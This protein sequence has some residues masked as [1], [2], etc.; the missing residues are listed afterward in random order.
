MD[1][2]ELQRS[3]MPG[4]YKKR[5]RTWNPLTPQLLVE[6]IKTWTLNN[7]PLINALAFKGD[8]P[9]W[10]MAALLNQT[11]LHHAPQPESL[12]QTETKQMLMSLSFIGSSVERHAQQQFV[13]QDF[14]PDIPDYARRAARITPGKGLSALWVHQTTPFIAY[15][16]QLADQIGHPYRD[17]VMSLVEYNGP[18]VEVR[19]PL[20][21]EP[22]YRLRGGVGDQRFLTFSGTISEINF[23]SLVKETMALQLAANLYLEQLQQPS[24]RLDSPEALEAATTTAHLM[25]AIKAQ[26][27]HF[28]QHKTFEADFFLDV[29]RQYQCLWYPGQYL[30]PPSGANDPAPL[31]RDLILFDNLVEPGDNFPG[32]RGHVQEICSVLM[33]EQR[34]QM[35]LAMAQPSLEARLLGQ[36]G[37]SRAAL[38]RLDSGGLSAVTRQHPWL[39]LYWQLYNAQRDLSHT[40]Y[41]LVL[42]YITRPKQERE[43]QTDRREYVTVVNNARGTTGMDPLGIMV[44]LDQA[45]AQHPLARLNENNEV[46]RLAKSYL[47]SLGFKRLTHEQLLALSNFSQVG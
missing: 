16:K 28:M 6:T 15:F 7:L 31:Q 30:K 25:W 45:R 14:G 32:F 40:H 37:L 17:T 12:P 24:T 27:L 38:A 36:L 39:L 9:Y 44:R 23:F 21:N 8:L 34:L 2:A 18:D 33:P 3:T 29:F 26:M 5:E 47:P 11:V 43:M 4:L 13:K 20:T 1:L 41:A 19:H 10:E 22:I 35:Q 46:K 42:K